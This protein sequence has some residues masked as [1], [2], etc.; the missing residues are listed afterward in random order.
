M[1]ADPVRLHH[2]GDVVVITID[3]PPVNVTSQPVRAGLMAAL[4][5]A[6]QSGAARIVLT[7]A[8]RAFVAGADVREFDAPP[9]PPALP[10]VVARI[11]ASPVPVVVAINGAALGGGLELA[12]ACVA[13]V[14]APGAMLG[15]SEVTLGV[16]PG[17]GGTQRLPRLIGLA[18]AVA[19]L[20][21]GRVIKA[22]AAQAIGLVD[23]LDDDPLTH[24]AQMVLPDR[25][26]TG[27]RPNP[28]TDD[29][30]LNAARARAA[31]RSPR[32]IAPQRAIDLVA[33]S[34]RLP[35]DQGLALERAAFLDL[36]TGDQAAALRHVFFAERAA[37]G[38][39]R[40]GGDPIERA[41]VVGGGTMGAGIAYVLAQAGI[42][43]ATVEADAAAVE[44]AR[45]NLARLY[46]D[47]VTR[48]KATAQQAA[49]DQAARHSFHSGYGDLPPAQIA[50]EAVPED[51]AAKQ[52]VF[53]ALDAA[54]PADAILATNT[55]YLNPDAIAQPLRDPSRFLGLHFFSPAHVMKLVEV[56]RA[57]ATAPKALT[58]ALRLT[59]RLGKIPV[60]A[61]V[62]DGFIGNRILTR[63]RQ[64]CDV[65]LIQGA[66]P[67][68]VDAAMRG[69]GMAMGPYEV[70]DLSGLD[71]AYANRKRLNWASQPGVR[72]VPIADRIVET[73]RL[74]RKTGAGWYDYDGGTATPSAMIDAIVTQ[75]SAEAGITRRAFSDE[76]IVARATTAMIAEGLQILDEGIATAPSDVDL[77]LVHGYGFPRWRGG[78][79]H[80]AGRAGLTGVLA[81][82]E[83]YAAADPLSWQVPA[84][85]RRAVETGVGL[86]ELTGAP[87]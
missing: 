4:D 69:W 56:I 77:V 80:Y 58:T 38:L 14:A 74:G 30:A 16:V 52:Q 78:P 87:G 1:T 53:A 10:D 20:S 3:N 44:R 26:A 33:A 40:K 7:G 59:A 24:A 6:A 27:A 37:M 82:I 62:C 2:D 8:G 48:G 32:Q 47:A 11:E 76:E 55:S 75:A 31:K 23:A 67:A 12:L 49:A 29:A 73:G 28:A 83:G 65:M 63:Y 21:E 15:L 22:D 19:M 64:I 50:I 61:G 17:A 45:G 25:P 9:Q 60:L 43:V 70:Q 18:Q 57:R 42:Q 79:L 84:I 66:L 81:R 85:L 36:K 72:Y 35:L 39:G 71:I 86:D 68:Q 51:L 54:L 41:V 13:R 5:A 34:A 46:A